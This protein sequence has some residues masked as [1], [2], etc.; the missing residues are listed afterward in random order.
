MT[1]IHQLEQ[2]ET[3][4][5]SHG[6][7]EVSQG[8]FIPYTLL[9]GSSSQPLITISAAVHGCEYVGVKT[10]LDLA[11]QWAFKEKG[12]IL[13][14]HAVNVTGFLSK[15][16]TLVPEDRLNLNRIFQDTTAMDSLSYRIKQTIC[17]NVLAHSDY[18]ID[19]HGG[20]K[21]ELLTPH[22]YYAAMAT[23]ETAKES[24]QMLLATGTPIIYAST[25]TGGLYQAGALDFNIPSI[26]LE[27]GDLGRC[28]PEDVR[29][30]TTAVLN[31]VHYI[32]HRTLPQNERQ[33]RIFN[34]W[35]EVVSEQDGC[36]SCV[37]LPNEPVKKGEVIGVITDLFGNVLS[38]KVAP[39]DGVV[40]FQYAPL[41][42]RAN[43]VLV[44]IVSD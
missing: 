26:L 6:E 13:L 40:L 35:Y 43:D 34:K 7:L 28:L 20:N 4:S 3:F 36:W 16:T 33:P 38:E 2:M 12:S 8:V 32:F 9:K 18:V 21:D 14:L 19:L 31:V 15:T 1:I 27:Q 37:V 30:M 10:T 29:I 23:E 44:T 25:A 11:Q 24:Y 22:G 41:V 5:R 17:T 39:V 42:T